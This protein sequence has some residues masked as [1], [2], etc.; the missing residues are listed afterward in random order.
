MTTNI[1]AGAE[2]AEVCQ[3]MSASLE[4]AIHEVSSGDPWLRWI[5]ELWIIQ[6]DISFL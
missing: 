5:W 4:N 1:H 2:I 3:G 6:Y